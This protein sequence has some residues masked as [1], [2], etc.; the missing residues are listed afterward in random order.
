[1]P[2]TSDPLNLVIEFLKEESAAP[3][4]TRNFTLPLQDHHYLE[5]VCPLD[6]P[7]S[8]SSPFGM[9]VTQRAQEGGGWL[10]WVV[11]VDDVS[12][13]ESR[14]ARPAVDGHRELLA[15]AMSPS[16]FSLAA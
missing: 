16:D 12:T 5:V 1:M 7:A 9:A 15:S 4:I 10:T 14:L 6:H 2:T 8:D 11:S 13:I 3:L